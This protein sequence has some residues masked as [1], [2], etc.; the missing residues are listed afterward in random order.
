M[1]NGYHLNLSFLTPATP[2]NVIFLSFL[3]FLF[4]H[5]E[6]WLLKCQKRFIF[7]ISF[8]ERTQWDLAG[9][10]KYFAQTV[11]NFL[12]SLAE[13]KKKWAIFD[14]L[15]A[16]TL[17]VNMITRQMTHF[18]FIFSPSSILWYFIFACPGIQNS[19]LW[20]PSLRC[21]LVC[22]I[23]IGT[24]KMTFSGLLT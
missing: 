7:C 14:I 21:A 1:K 4:L 17:G 20:G 19:F 22:K 12:L 8:P 18:S 11:T 15:M 6:L 23:H 16:I 24:S 10:L 5:L 13:N 9:Q 3:L 2:P